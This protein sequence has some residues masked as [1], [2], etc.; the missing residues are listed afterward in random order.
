MVFELKFVRVV[1]G[2]N[3]IIKKFI[4][5]KRDQFKLDRM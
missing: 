2:K 4:G 3:Y 1:Y 5:D